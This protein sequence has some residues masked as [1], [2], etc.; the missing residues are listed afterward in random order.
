MLRLNHGVL[1]FAASRFICLRQGEMSRV[2]YDWYNNPVMADP[3]SQNIIPSNIIHGSGNLSADPPI[4]PPWMP[5]RRDMDWIDRQW[6]MVVLVML[7]SGAVFLGWRAIFSVML[8]ACSTI[9][10]YFSLAL[11]IHRMR[12]GR[13][14]HA[15]LH[16]PS[17]LINPL[18]ES[19]THVIGMG[20]LLGG[21]LPLTRGV[22][23]PLMAGSLLG[24]AMH[25]V[26]RSRRVRVHPLAVV[27]LVTC[28][29][30]EAIHAIRHHDEAA[31]AAQL[32][33]WWEPVNTVLQP[34]AVFTGDAYNVEGF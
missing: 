15:T 19:L 27:M 5:T 10:A 34:G 21:C 25:G 16:D 3:S 17:R 6:L 29:A 11:V 32:H 12:R 33:R 14:D 9:I 30:P 13:R 18:D 20:L 2:V 22:T 28:L 4:G 31:P 8:A 1:N 24:V 7:V 23:L 26:G